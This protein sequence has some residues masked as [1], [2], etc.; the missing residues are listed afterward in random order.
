M[1]FTIG[2][3]LMLGLISV[4]LGFIATYLERIA[5]ALAGDARPQEESERSEP[6]SD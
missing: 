3:M 4:M 1:I 6:E 2:I 5:V